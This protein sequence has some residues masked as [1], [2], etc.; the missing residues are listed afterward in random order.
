MTPTTRSTRS[1]PA[2]PAHRRARALVA[3]AGA[4]AVIG[5]PALAGASARTAPGAVA[6][7]GALGSR[8]APAKTTICSK[9]SPSAVSAI[10][11]WTVPAGTYTST[12][13]AANAKDDDIASVEQSCLYG[14]YTSAAGLAHIVTLGIGTT[15]KPITN[16][17]LQ[18]LL[19]TTEAAAHAKLAFTPYGGLGFPA[20]YITFK[21]GTDEVQEIAGVQG[22]HW[23]AGA[24]FTKALPEA[25]VG[26]LAK[27]AEQ[28]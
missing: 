15:S 20:W 1:A 3:L 13:L 19:Q 12:S 5:A 11:G 16:A 6:Q 24:V 28:L 27:L 21:I 14:S 22:T 23:V 10:V 2:R 9:V 4:T 25:K 17:V 18:K 8:L 7:H 26:S